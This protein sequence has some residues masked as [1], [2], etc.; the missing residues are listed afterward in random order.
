[1][2]L[3]LTKFNPQTVD[4]LVSALEAGL[5]TTATTW[6][7]AN[8]AAVAGDLKML[9]QAAV[10]TQAALLEGRITQAYA[11]TAIQM[12]KETL[13][14]TIEF[15]ELMTMALAQQLLNSVTATIG[16]AIYNKTGINLF[17]DVVQPAAAAA[18]G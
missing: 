5:S 17:P 4:Q 15:T 12:Q 13:Q 11:Q 2:G 8:S 6:Y 9:A 10:E 3:D 14:Q 7:N 1:M 18:G 16:W